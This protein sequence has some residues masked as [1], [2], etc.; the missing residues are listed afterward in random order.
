MRLPK[1]N[2]A[3]YWTS[4]FQGFT[5]PISGDIGMVHYMLSVG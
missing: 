4:N 3:E 5:L 2:V 1:P